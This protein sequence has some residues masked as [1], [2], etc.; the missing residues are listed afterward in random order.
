[1]S[2]NYIRKYYFSG[3]IADMTKI[4]RM[5]SRLDSGKGKLSS[6]EEMSDTNA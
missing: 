6:V 3:V 5:M 2:G 4:S 1:M